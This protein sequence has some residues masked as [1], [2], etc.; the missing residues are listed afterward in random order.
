MH[1]E[2]TFDKYF[3]YKDRRTISD[4]FAIKD[5][6]K[7]L[8]FE[9][10]KEFLSQMTEQE[11]SDAESIFFLILNTTKP[12]E[13]IVQSFRV[14]LGTLCT[15]LGSLLKEVGPG[16]DRS[17]SRYSEIKEEALAFF[18]VVGDKMG[19]SK[20]SKKNVLN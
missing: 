1:L 3:A 13:E 9:D 4:Y 18:Y 8:G 7:D 2:N 12:S 15:A 17:Q 5:L 11:K 16:I 20:E 6:F 14:Y 10:S 19:L